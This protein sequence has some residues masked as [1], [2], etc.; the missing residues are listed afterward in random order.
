[1]SDAICEDK[2]HIIYK[3]DLFGN[4]LARYVRDRGGM[5]FEFRRPSRYQ[6]QDDRYKR[7]VEQVNKLALFL[8]DSLRNL[9]NNKH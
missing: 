1:M 6:G 9:T 8:L 4:R 2:L 7:E 5:L 3:E